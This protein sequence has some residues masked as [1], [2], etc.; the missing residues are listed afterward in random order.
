MNLEGKPT[1]GRP[2]LE[3]VGIPKGVGEHAL[4]LPQSVINLQGGAVMS[5]MLQ[6]L[7]EKDREILR[8]YLIRRLEEIKHL[9][10]DDESY[11][12]GASMELEMAMD[13]LLGEEPP[14]ET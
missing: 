1:K 5:N 10:K 7:S 8:A 12:F 6:L 2:R 3:I 9:K 11:W 13:E 4:C 14:T